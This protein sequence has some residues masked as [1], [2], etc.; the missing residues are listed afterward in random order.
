MLKLY[1]SHYQNN[2]TFAISFVMTVHD[3]K[4]NL[5]NK[6]IHEKSQLVITIHYSA[7]SDK[8]VSVPKRKRKRVTE[9]SGVI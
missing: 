9:K 5:K 3:R 6:A 7:D 1:L 2:P 8:K 4:I